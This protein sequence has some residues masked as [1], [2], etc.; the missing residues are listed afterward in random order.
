MKKALYILIILLSMSICNKISAYTEYKIGDV[1]TYNDIDFYVIK[2][3]GVKEDSVTM[4]KA[5]PLSYSEVNVI[6]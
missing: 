5:E 1:V 3:S 2:D 4:L 6:L